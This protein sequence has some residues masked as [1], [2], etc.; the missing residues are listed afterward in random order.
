[1]ATLNL[2][3]ETDA[4]TWKIQGR[5]SRNLRIFSQYHANTAIAY[6]RRGGCLRYLRHIKIDTCFDSRVEREREQGMVRE[7]RANAKSTLETACFCVIFFM[8]CLWTLHIT[9]FLGHKPSPPKRHQEPRRG[10]ERAHPEGP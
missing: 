2:H 3:A 9:Q 5:P 6:A 8:P 10:E 1:M 4:E 7:L